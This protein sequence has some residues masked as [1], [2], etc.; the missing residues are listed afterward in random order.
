MFTLLE[1]L[2]F[3]LSPWVQRRMRP[4]HDLSGCIYD[5]SPITDFL[6]SSMGGEAFQGALKSAWWDSDLVL[7][8]SWRK[9]VKSSWNNLPLVQ[10]IALNI[11][12]VSFYYLFLLS[13]TSFFPHP[14]PHVLIYRF[15][16]K[17][18]EKAEPL[19]RS[20]WKRVYWVLNA[21]FVAKRSK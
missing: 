1:S 2:F 5:S 4:G 21:E 15:L 18:R 7:V 11:T 12:C 16:I 10:N 17:Q 6:L 20:L 19:C 3:L 9:W 8:G 14:P 13:A